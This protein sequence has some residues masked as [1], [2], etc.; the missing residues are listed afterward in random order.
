MRPPFAY[1]GSRLAVE[2]CKAS[3]RSNKGLVRLYSDVAAES[4][5]VS[6]KR[7]VAW[8][9]SKAL[10]D[11]RRV[12]HVWPSGKVSERVSEVPRLSNAE[13]LS[14]ETRRS[15]WLIRERS[16]MRADGATPK[17]LLETRMADL[18]FKDPLI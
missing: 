2:Q 11:R 1:Y 9:D 14:L 18:P 7:P 12:R 17:P 8:H 5:D 13:S 15:H 16:R 4:V 3:H 10:I 6:A